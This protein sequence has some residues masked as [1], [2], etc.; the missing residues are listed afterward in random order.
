MFRPFREYQ[1]AESESAEKRRTDADAD[2]LGRHAEVC[3]LPL[4][5]ERSTQHKQKNNAL[6][7]GG[8]K[9]DSYLSIISCFELDHDV[10]KDVLATRLFLRTIS[11]L[12]IFWQSPKWNPAS[13]L[14]SSPNPG[15]PRLMVLLSVKLFEGESCMV[16]V[17]FHPYT[18]SRSLKVRLQAE[19]VSFHG[20]RDR[21]SVV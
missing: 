9:A 16:Q 5:L 20:S 4:Q 2:A 7:V 13:E 19:G 1:S 12:Q 8:S 14:D 11:R 21:K 6:V 17:W 15:P 3:Y 10:L 18:V